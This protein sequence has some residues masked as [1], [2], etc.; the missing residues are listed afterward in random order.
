[1]VILHS[2]RSIKD[3]PLKTNTM[4]ISSI[5]KPLGNVVMFKNIGKLTVEKKKNPRMKAM[6]E[7]LLFFEH[8]SKT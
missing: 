4:N 7:S 2:F 6:F 3:L 5:G 1:M 8:H